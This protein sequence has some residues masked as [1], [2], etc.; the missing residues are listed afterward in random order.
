MLMK[1]RPSVPGEEEDPPLEELPLFV[2]LGA[3]AG[4]SV[5]SCDDGWELD[6]VVLFIS[7]HHFSSWR[8]SVT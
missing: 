7:L 6:V 3:E 2:V 1:S 5:C 8:E 4:V